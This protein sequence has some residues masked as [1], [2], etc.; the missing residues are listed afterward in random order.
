MV[1]VR[2][3]TDEKTGRRASNLWITRVADGESWALTRGAASHSS[4]RWSPDGEL[5]AFSSSRPLPGKAGGEGEGAS[6]PAALGPP[7]RRRRALAAHHRRARPRRLRLEGRLVRLAGVRRPRRPPPLRAGGA[8]RARTTRSRWRTR[9][10]PPPVRLWSVAVEGAALRRITVHDDRIE[11]FALCPRR[12]LRRHPEHAR[13]SRTT[14]TRRTAAAHLPG[15]PRL[16]RAPR[17][18]RR[19]RGPG[20]PPLPDRPLGDGVVRR[21]FAGSTSPTTTP[22]TRSTARRAWRAWGY[23]D[24]AAHRFA[25]ID[26]GWEPGL[27]GGFEVVPGGFIALLADGVADRLARFSRAGNDW[28]R[29]MIEGEHAARVDA[30]G[31]SPSGDRVAYLTSTASTPPQP[32]TARLEGARLSGAT[33][34]GRAETPPSRR[35]RSR[36]PRRS[37]GPA[38][39]ARRS[40]GMLYYPLDHQPGRRYPLIV[41]IHGGPASRD[42]DAWSQSWAYPLVLFN[43]RGR[44]RP[45]AQL[46][47]EQRLRVGLGRVDRGRELLRPGGARHPGGG[48]APDLPGN[49]AP[50]QRRHP[51]VE[52]RRDPLHRADHP[53]PGALQGLRRGSRRRRVD[54]RLGKRR[55]RRLVRQLLLRCEPA[56]GPAA[57][58]REEPVLPAGPGEDPHPDLLRHRGPERSAEPGVE[59]VPRA[60]AARQ[61]AGAAGAL[62]RRAARYREARLP[63]PK[64]EGGAGLAR[65]LSLGAPR[66]RQPRA[67][68]RARRWP[69]SSA[70]RTPLGKAASWESA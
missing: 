13:L 49:G 52:Q 35:S 62:P 68:G 8:G 3:A 55:L 5:V 61:R 48:R 34:P 51:G 44:L 32:F 54:L 47:R 67:R 59:P 42:R 7:P 29:A 58:P 28:R 25:P 36:A 33:R 11:A 26:L 70:W 16:G 15:G 21:R 31:V 39:A 69:G 17:D 41:S 27:A 23:Y 14:S 2:S 46:P 43:Q 10:T 18:P 65:P 38:R 12:P 9:S 45:Q 56:G 19:L 37:A 22:P 4:P 60:A 1:W 40:R 57:L 24:V 64:G 20:R 6:G 30:L 53:R 50:R 63:A 66:H